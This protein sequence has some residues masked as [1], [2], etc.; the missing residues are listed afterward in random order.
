[1]EQVSSSEVVEVIENGQ[2]ATFVREAWRLDATAPLSLIRKTL[3]GGATRSRVVL[4]HGFAQNRYSW[5]TRTRSIENWLAQR[6]WDVWNLE[7]RGTGLS[8]DLG[9]VAAERFDDYVDDVVAVAEHFGGDAYFVGHSMGGGAVYGAATRT[10]MKGVVGVAAMYGFGGANEIL[11]AVCRTSV[12]LE[13]VIADWG[14]NVK[15]RLAGRIMARLYGLSD[16][17]GYWFPLSGWWPGSVERELLDE[18]LVEGFDWTSTQVWREMARWCTEGFPY[19]TAWESTDVPLLVL[20]GDEDAL[21]PPDDG[22]Q[23]YDASGS[24]D[25]TLKVFGFEHDEVHWG[26]LDLVLGRLATRHIWSFVDD[27]LL[28]RESP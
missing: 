23:A 3:P 18:R 17:L 10:P 22:R 1:M 11:G 27:W 26:H 13:P 25:K 6:G 28:E 5:H 21:M 24:S 7:L 4:V 14:V 9:T 2:T 16:V 15:T 12:A 20:L 8:R 19:A